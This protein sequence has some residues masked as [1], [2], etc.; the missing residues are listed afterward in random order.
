MAL[1]FPIILFI[2]LITVLIFTGTPEA[3]LKIS[4]TIFLFVNSNKIADT[5]S[6]M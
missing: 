5:V 1:P 3:T 6:L 2:K 4:P